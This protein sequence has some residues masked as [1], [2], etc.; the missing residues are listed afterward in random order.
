M[1]STCFNLRV[2]RHLL[3]ASQKICGDSFLASHL[4]IIFTIPPQV[5][6]IYFAKSLAS[7]ISN[8]TQKI[9]FVKTSEATATR[10]AILCIAIQRYKLIRKFETLPT[11]KEVKTEVLTIFCFV[12]NPPPQGLVSWNMG[13]LCVFSM[14]FWRMLKGWNTNGFLLRWPCP[15][16][17]MSITE[18]F[19]FFWKG[20]VGEWLILFWEPVQNWIW[21]TNTRRR[22]CFLMILMISLHR[23]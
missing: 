22:Q 4:L 13:F 1:N 23:S 3:D 19:D 12:W 11:K 8:I 20:H 18:G 2:V 14:G 21:S 9:H 5:A 15:V 16:Y 17:T 6:S 7:F 10:I